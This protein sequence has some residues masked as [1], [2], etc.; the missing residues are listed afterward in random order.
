MIGRLSPE[1]RQ[2]VL[3]RAVMKSRYADRIQLYFAGSGPGRRNFAV[4]ETNSPILLCL[5]ITIVTS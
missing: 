5:G 1:K 3:I 2:D 4:L